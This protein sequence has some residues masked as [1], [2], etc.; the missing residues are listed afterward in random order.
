MREQ[1]KSKSKWEI[2]HFVVVKSKGKGKGKE[3][4]KQ[5]SNL[6][7][8]ANQL[9]FLLQTRVENKLLFKRQCL[10]SVFDM[11]AIIVHS[12][13][14]PDQ[15][16]SCLQ[17]LNGKC[18]AQIWWARSPYR[19][20]ITNSPITDSAA[21]TQYVA[22]YPSMTYKT[23][24]NPYPDLVHDSSSPD[25]VLMNSLSPLETLCNHEDHPKHCLQLPL[26][27][28]WVQEVSSCLSWFWENL[29]NVTKHN[30]I[31][32]LLVLYK[33]GNLNPFHDRYD[34]K[35]SL[36]EMKDKTERFDIAST[37]IQTTFAWDCTGAMSQRFGNGRQGMYHFRNAKTS[38]LMQAMDCQTLSELNNSKDFNFPIEQFVFGVVARWIDDF[39][40]NKK[41]NFQKDLFRT[42]KYNPSCCPR[43]RSCLEFGE[44]CLGVQKRV[45]SKES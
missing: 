12:T 45:D 40:P 23:L 34:S 15:W 24:W 18:E 17:K 9:F 39:V 41:A 21:C 5:E 31:L 19:Q 16:E 30:Q 29:K 20:L 36:G 3:D 11:A 37:H 42:E 10:R 14:D 2:E 13:T 26:P 38:T 32:K 7:T 4:T 28:N 33:D 25:I 43:V 1:M 8:L 35:L 44:R 22:V 27:R 6:L